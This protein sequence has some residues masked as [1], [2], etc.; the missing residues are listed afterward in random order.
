MAESQRTGAP[1]P[2]MPPEW[3]GARAGP[4]RGG[5]GRR[6][7]RRGWAL[8]RAIALAVLTGLLVALIIA[9]IFGALVIAIN[10]KLP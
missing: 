9:T 4:R 8:V 1:Q 5:F 2:A 7:A 6:T 10:G 3:V